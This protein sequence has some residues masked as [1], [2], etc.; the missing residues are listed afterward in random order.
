MSYCQGRRGRRGAQGPAGDIGEPG[1]PGL[2]GTKGEPGTPGLSV[3]V[4]W[5][6]PKRL[7][8]VTPSLI[9]MIFLLILE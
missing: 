7:H 1:L 6:L 3:R 4:A 5:V 8:L 2:P 9:C